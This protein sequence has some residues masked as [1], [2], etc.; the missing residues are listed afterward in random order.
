MTDYNVTVGYRPTLG[1][2]Q[3]AAG[4]VGPA[5]PAGVGIGTT[6]S[7]NTSGII[8]ASYFVGNGS[9]LTNIGYASTA[10]IATYATSSGIATYASTSGVSTNVIG[11]IASVTSLSVSG[12]S[13]FTNGSVLI[14]SGTSTGTSSQRLQVT[15]GGYISGSLG[16]GVTNPQDELHLSATSNVGI[17]L[18]DTAPGGGSY[19]T[20][21]YNDTGSGTN[22]LSLSADSGNTGANSEIR[23]AID[24]NDVSRYAVGGQ[25]LV[26]AATTTG[27]ASQLLQVSGGAYIGGNHGVGHTNPTSRL[28]VVGN[29]SVSGVSTFT[30]DST[31][32]NP[33]IFA[34]RDANNAAGIKLYATSSGNFVFSEST[35]S[36]GKPLLFDTSQQENIF[37]RIAGNAKLIIQPSGELLVGSSTSTGTASQL[38]QVDGGAYVSGNLGIGTTTPTSKLQVIGTALITG[39]TTVGLGTTS[40]PPSNSQMSFEL[41][42]D[43]NLRIK[44][45]GTDG[46]LRSAN[47]TLA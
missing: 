28:S 10:G 46:V 31:A 27:T 2:T 13:T 37:F 26:G 20:I 38:L 16:I 17:R 40:T 8:T 41:T 32:G 6:F 18:E 7:V 14:G 35:S 23:F 3:Q 30:G 47:I 19:A 4:L 43:T 12:I 45:R 9:L 1:V 44:V 5:G 22:A 33:P 25:L 39:I 21:G 11:G 24:G 15:G 42:S 29:I 34:R 36:N